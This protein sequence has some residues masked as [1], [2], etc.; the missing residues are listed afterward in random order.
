[1]PLTINDVTPSGDTA[2]ALCEQFDFQD[3]RGLPR[4][5]SCS[6]AL[7]KLEA[8]GKISLPV[9]PTGSGARGHPKR[10]EK[11]VPSPL[12]VPDRVDRIAGLHV[13]RVCDDHHHRIFNELMAREHP[14]GSVFQA[15][16]QMRYLIGS[17]HGWLGGLGF[18]ASA[19]R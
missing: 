7:A 8:S 13:S 12:E 14:M 1:M 15:G 16:A 3:A 11:A 4:I 5:S 2:W 9:S 19:Y 6:A 17:D 18:S 10:L